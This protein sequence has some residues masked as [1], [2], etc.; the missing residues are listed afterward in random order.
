[1][2][3]GKNRDGYFTSKNI[4]EQ[5][6]EAMDIITQFYPKYECWFYYDNVSTHLKRPAGA[7]S[8]RNMPNIPPS[9]EITDWS[10]W[11]STM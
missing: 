10:K 1:M 4:K 11:Q 8:A 6:Q 5:A 7:P 9:L 3:P 2:R